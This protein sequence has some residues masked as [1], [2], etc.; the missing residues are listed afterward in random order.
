[1]AERV[2][3][4]KRAEYSNLYSRTQLRKMRRKPKDGAEPEV[5]IYREDRKKRK[6]FPLYSLENTEERIKDKRQ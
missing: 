6:G 1:M 4:S 2:E 3:R 5:I